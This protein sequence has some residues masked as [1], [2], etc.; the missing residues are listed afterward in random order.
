MA[1]RRLFGG[2]DLGGTKIE[3]VI[4]DER[5]VVL[6][7]ARHPTP[8]EG[9]PAS[10]IQAL[11]TALREATRQA[12]LESMR[13]EGVGVGAPGTVDPQAGTLANA[14]N[15]PGWKEPY[16]L[17]AELSERVQAP[18][19]LG[20]DVTVAVDAE[21]RLGA[22]RPYRSL[23]GIWCGTGV[24]S[25]LILDGRRWTGRG[26]GGEFGHMVVRQGGAR[27][28]C[29]RRGCVEAYA[30]RAS[31]ERCA[32]KAVSRGEKTVLFELMEKHERTRLTSGIWAR[33]LKQ[34]D[35]LAQRLIAKAI[36][37]LAAGIASAINLLDVEAVLIGGGLGSRLGEPFVERVAEAMTPHLFVPQ[38]P[39]AMHL[40]ALGDLAGAIGAALLIAAPDAELSTL[41][42]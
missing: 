37:K 5:G 41:P 24:G 15:L 30:G 6:G 10:I 42:A 8:R 19:R 18:V 38:R 9:G 28:G 4:T 1:E 27:C 12:G 7:R 26:A 36:R 40:A 39:P 16:P 2:L 25:G 13:L 32:R 3:A 31:L 21:F 20:N 11:D 35:P 14:G 22:G 34:G 17:A 23:L 29:G 33:A